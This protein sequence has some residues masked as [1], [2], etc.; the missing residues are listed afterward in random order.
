MHAALPRSRAG[1]AQRPHGRR[2]CRFRRAAPADGRLHDQLRDRARLPRSVRTRPRRHH[3]DIRDRG[4]GGRSC[5]A[6]R[7]GPATARRRHPRPVHARDPDS[8]AAGG[9]V[10]AARIG[11]A[12]SAAAQDHD[13]RLRDRAA[14]R[15]ADV[16]RG[17]RRRCLGGRRAF[18]ARRRRRPGASFQDGNGARRGRPSTASERASRPPLKCGVRSGRRAARGRRLPEGRGVSFKKAIDPDSTARRR[19]PTWRSL[20]RVGTRSTKRPAR[21]RRRWS[22]AAISRRSTTGSAGR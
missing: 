2:P 8:A 21:C 22:T 3:D 1:D 6:R 20:R 19:S 10:R 4:I 7:T 16:S 17:P 5:V 14:G 11:A 18:P 12:V 15:A 13:A 9:Q